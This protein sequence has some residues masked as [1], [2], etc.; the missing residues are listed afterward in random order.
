MQLDEFEFIG[1]LRHMQRYFSHICDGTKL[2][3]GG[4]K[5]LYLRSGSQRNW[6]FA[7]FFNVPALHGHGTTLLI[8][9]YDT[10]GVRRMHWEM[11]W[12]SV[13]YVT[14][15]RCAGGLKKLDLRYGS[16]RQDIHVLGHHFSTFNT[17]LAEDH[18]CGFITRNAHMVHIVNNI[19]FKMVYAS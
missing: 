16:Q 7:G 9:F 17:T 5:K 3:A 18:W 11:N 6:H 14:A 13:I 19:R 1:V 15:H 12:F 8:T 2:C 10:L 4:L